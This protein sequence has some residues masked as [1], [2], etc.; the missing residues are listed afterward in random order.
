MS[1]SLALKA[2]PISI[3]KLIPTPTPTEI[4]KL[5]STSII[6]SFAL[7]T[8]KQINI[9][10]TKVQQSAEMKGTINS[11][12]LPSVQYRSEIS[13]TNFSIGIIVGIAVGLGFIVLCIVITIFLMHRKYFLH[14]DKTGSEAHPPGELTLTVSCLHNHDY[15]ITLIPAASTLRKMHT[16]PFYETK[17]VR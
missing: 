13:S 16:N 4:N 8:I 6:N 12:I 14:D 9:T 15:F 2:L 3:S 17:E 11:T 1:T 10:P 7:P 5:E